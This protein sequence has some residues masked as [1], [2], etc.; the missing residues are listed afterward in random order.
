MSIFPL[1][2][3]DLDINFKPLFLFFLNQLIIFLFFLILVE[4]SRAVL[5]FEIKMSYISSKIGSTL[6]IS[7]DSLPIAIMS[8]KLFI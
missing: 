4:L 7:I 1:Y 6:V 5:T 2:R 3:T 8:Y